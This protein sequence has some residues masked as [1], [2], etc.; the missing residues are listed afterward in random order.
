MAIRF[1]LI[2]FD[3]NKSGELLITK[4]RGLALNKKKL[5]LCLFSDLYQITMAYA[6]WK[7]GKTNDSA[8]FDMFFRKNPFHGE[9]TI[10]AGLEEVLKFLTNF[11]YSD[12]DIEY[13]RDTLPQ[14]VEDE[15]FEYLRNLTAQDVV[16]YGIEEGSVVFPRVPLL[17]IEGPLI[18]VQ[19]LET[20]LLTLVNYAS[21]MATNAARYRMVAGKSSQ[22]LEF[23][24][25]RAQ[26]P[27]GGL[28]ASK[29]AYIGKYGFSFLEFP[30][31]DML[32]PMSTNARGTNQTLFTSHLT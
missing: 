21:L 6:Y 20:T 1:A 31:H 7:S 30:S 29:Y 25:R 12:G 26:G 18:V 4:V 10:F 28:S 27:D 5:E 13:L 32:V 16:L 24:L 15:F 14:G 11:R 23:G 19:L 3:G 9:F 17:K 2:A 8:V 22:L